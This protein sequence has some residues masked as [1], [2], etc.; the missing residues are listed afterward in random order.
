MAVSI[1]ISKCIY[2]GACVA[3]CPVFALRLREIVVEWDK[4]KCIHC[5]NC[6]KACP[7]GAIIVKKE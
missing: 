4:A 3:V 1:D 5:G 7:A 2:C 6:E